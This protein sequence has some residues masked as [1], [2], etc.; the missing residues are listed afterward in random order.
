MTINQAYPLISQL[1]AKAVENER[2]PVE[3]TINGR[4][5]R[6]QYRLD[7]RIDGVACSP[8]S[9]HQIATIIARDK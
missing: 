7:V 9:L 5:V 6:M 3:A 4:I 1:E 2:L 8:E